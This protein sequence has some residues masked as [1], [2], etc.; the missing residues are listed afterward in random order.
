M[1]LV[2][3]FRT[4]ED[5]TSHELSIQAQTRTGLVTNYLPNSD[6]EIRWLLYL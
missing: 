1:G 3:F 2:G 4:N 5:G 6:Y